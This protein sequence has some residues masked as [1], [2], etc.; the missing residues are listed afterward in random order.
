MIR[1][2]TVAAIVVLGATSAA[3]AQQPGVLQPTGE[4]VRSVTVNATGTVR[5]APDQAVISLAVETMAKN[6]RD[7]AQQN[8]DRME[9]VIR[10][11]RQSGIPGERIRTTSY[12]LSPEYQ[13]T[14]PT[15]DRPGEQKLL[16]Y[17]ASNQVEVRVDSIPRV[18]VVLDA[19]IGA[20]A[21]RAMGISYQLRDPDS[22]RREALRAAVANA[23]LDAEAIATAAGQQLGPVIQMNVGGFV[24]P[25]PVPMFEARK[26]MDMAA[27][28]PTPVEA[29]QMEITASVTA[30]YRLLAGG[31]GSR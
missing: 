11:I 10:A 12:S 22:A 15:P 21:N 9:R 19:A 1:A 13:Y 4:L 2:F 31:S 16:G 14:Q 20:G 25:P 30:V 7:A 23:R 28:A 17:R 27:Q 8:A 5:R 24:Q 18:G 6:A 26:A 3:R 29:G